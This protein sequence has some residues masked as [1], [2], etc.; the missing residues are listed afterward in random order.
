MSPDPS[1][2]NPGH[3]SSDTSGDSTTGEELGQVTARQ[4]FALALPALGVLAAMPLYLLL[5]TAVVGRLG[6]F[7]L[8]ALG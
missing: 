3:H 1:S 4:I 7:E 8:A 2:G 5:D 6:G